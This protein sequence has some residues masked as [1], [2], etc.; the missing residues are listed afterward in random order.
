MLM[1]WDTP[2]IGLEWREDMVARHRV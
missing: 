2:G 1:P